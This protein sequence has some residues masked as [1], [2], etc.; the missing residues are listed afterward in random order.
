MDW[1]APMGDRARTI[2]IVVAVVIVLGA[3]ITA[4]ALGIPFF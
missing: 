4:I 1:S 3:V 2:V